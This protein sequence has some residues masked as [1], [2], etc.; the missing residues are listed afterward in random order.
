MEIWWKKELW[1]LFLNGA[2]WLAHFFKE[3]CH[4]DKGL[5]ILKTN[6]IL[7][8]SKHSIFLILFYFSFKQEKLVCVLC[9]HPLWEQQLSMN[10]SCCLTAVVVLCHSKFTK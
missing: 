7:W 2:V 4:N 6:K 8:P 9:P 10:C 3:K 5:N 1:K